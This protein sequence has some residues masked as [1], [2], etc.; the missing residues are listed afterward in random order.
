MRVDTTVG[1]VLLYVGDTI[2]DG[3]VLV[4][5]RDGVVE[6]RPYEEEA[7]ASDVGLDV[8]VDTT[9]GLVVLLYVGDI[10]CDGGVLVLVRDGVVEG[11]SNEE[12]AGASSRPRISLLSHFPHDF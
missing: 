12:E 9:V 4:L 3:G 1:L 2:C 11:R 6:G 8:R 5:V 10:I 7:G